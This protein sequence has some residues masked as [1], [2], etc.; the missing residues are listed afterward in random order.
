M[1]RP[2][3]VHLQSLKKEEIPE[4][5]GSCL[6]W[7]SRYYGEECAHE[8]EGALLWTVCTLYENDGYIVE[9]DAE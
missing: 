5:C 8:V 2:E 1:I 9:K 4:C 6:F 7:D 3:L